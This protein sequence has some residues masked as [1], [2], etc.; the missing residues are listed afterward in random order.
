MQNMLFALKYEFVTRLEFEQENVNSSATLNNNQAMK[1]M[2]PAATLSALEPVPRMSL[3]P[4]PPKGRNIITTFLHFSMR[5]FPT[6]SSRNWK[7]VSA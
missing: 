2:V 5:E 6:D 4:L 7:R 1:A 3:P